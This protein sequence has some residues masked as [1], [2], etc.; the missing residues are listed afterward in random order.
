MNNGP[1]WLELRDVLAYLYRQ[2]DEIITILDEVRIPA[3]RL[4][5]G[6]VALNSWS[7]VLREAHIL[8]KV[9]NIAR[10]AQRRYPNNPRLE[11]ALEAYKDAVATAAAQRTPN[12][13]TSVEIAPPSITLDFVQK[14]NF[15]TGKFASNFKRIDGNSAWN[16]EAFDNET[17]ALQTEL[18]DLLQLLRDVKMATRPNL[19]HIALSESVEAA[20]RAVTLG[21]RLQA[22]MMGLLSSETGISERTQL[23]QSYQS[24]GSRFIRQLE[25]VSQ[26]LQ[27]ELRE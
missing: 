20:D 3:E 9:L 10:I 26:A 13:E 14:F 21:N 19:H 8:G 25:I 15:A 24:T 5:I 6:H 11:A 27:R 22:S 12:E 16:R 2:R 17:L 7:E 18:P 23:A 1:P 4:S